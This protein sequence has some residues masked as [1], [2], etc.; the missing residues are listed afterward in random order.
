MKMIMI[1]VKP[2]NYFLFLPHK[3]TEKT[4]FMDKY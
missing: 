3:V 4:S 2:V 1:L